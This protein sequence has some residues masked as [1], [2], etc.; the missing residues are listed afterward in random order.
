MS[1][2]KARRAAASGK[3]ASAEDIPLKQPVR[4]KE[5][6]HKTLYDLATE[7]EA[8][9]FP[10]GPPAPSQSRNVKPPEMV[11][12]KVNSDGTI[13]HIKDPGFEH[14][15][16]PIGPFGYA[17]IYAITFTMLHFTLDVLVH[18]QYRMSID[19]DMIT[20]KTATAFPVLLF[21]VYILHPQASAVWAQALFFVGGVVAG[22]YLV[23]SS[24]VDPYFAV[25]KR[26]PALG[27]LWVWCVL[28]QRLAVALAGLGVVGAYF[29]WGDYAIFAL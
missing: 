1:N 20:W 11:T 10:D 16:D 5:V 3:V 19:W 24:N 14:G 2:R 13:S 12:T 29:W 27:T 8:E 9:L 18:N 23:K 6:S 4:E 22:C 15:D 7:R 26:A 25:M 28:E 17:F 21:L